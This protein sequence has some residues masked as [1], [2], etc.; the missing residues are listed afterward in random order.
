[1]SPAG[2]EHGWKVGLVFGPLLQFVTK[3]DLGVLTGSETGFVLQRHPDTVRAPDIGFV[4]RERIPD[5]PPVGFFPGHPD[6]AVEVLSPSDRASEVLEKVADWLNSGTV[7]VWL[8]DPR[9]RTIMVH[10]QEAA[11]QTFTADQT[12]TC[13]QV[14]PGFELPLSQVF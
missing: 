8:V 14:L 4:R 7:A 5:P 12:L 2:F 10:S 11:A 9:R 1:M 13:P 3:Y 6:L